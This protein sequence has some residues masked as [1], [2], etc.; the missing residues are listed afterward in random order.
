MI[1]LPKQWNYEDNYIDES[2][3]D[4]AIHEESPWWTP[5]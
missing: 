3:E 1:V 4:I 2:E 5:Y